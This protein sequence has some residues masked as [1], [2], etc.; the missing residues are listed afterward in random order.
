MTATDAPPEAAVPKVLLWFKVYAG[1]LAFIYAMCIALSFV[2]LLVPHEKLEMGRTEALV[3]GA[4][5]LVLGVVLLIACLLPFFLK[6][7]PWVWVYDLVLICLG[8]TSACFLPACIP[9]LIFWLKPETKNYFHR[10]RA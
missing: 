5:F 2:F 4:M 9:L 7:R 8:M 10:H 1:F 3:L 6:P